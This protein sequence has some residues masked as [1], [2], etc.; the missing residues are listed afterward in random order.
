MARLDDLLKQHQRALA[1]LSREPYDGQHT[2]EVRA[3]LIKSCTEA[4]AQIRLDLDDP[5]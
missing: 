1:D 2:P 4:I 5:D 3:I